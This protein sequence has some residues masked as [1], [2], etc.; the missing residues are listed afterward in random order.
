MKELAEATQ[1]PLSLSSIGLST[2][3]LDN[4][5]QVWLIPPR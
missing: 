5:A 3:Q 4:F 1:N 2:R